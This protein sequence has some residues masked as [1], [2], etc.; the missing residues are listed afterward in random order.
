MQ[1]VQ[2]LGSGVQREGVDCDGVLPQTQFDVPAVQELRQLPVAVPEV[3]DDREWVEL[4][5]ARDQKVEQEALAA[6]GGTEHQCVPDV[7]DVKVIV[8]WRTMRRLERRDRSR[9]QPGIR[10]S[11]VD[12]EK[13]AD[14][15]STRLNS[16][17]S[18]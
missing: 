9:Q 3:E 17:H 10:R 18:Q 8:E 4:L 16:S 2:V 13:E 1:K 11:S 14:R 15:K 7:F 12:G 6:A 5:R